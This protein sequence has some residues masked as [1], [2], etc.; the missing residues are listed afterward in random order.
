MT[1][2]TDIF[3]AFNQ[4]HILVIGDIMLDTYTFGDVYRISPEA[5][6][7][8]VNT[9]HT[10]SRLGGAANVALNLKSL[11]AKVS[12]CGIV[13]NDVGAKTIKELLCK[14]EIL[15]SGI[16]QFQQR[17]TTIKN[18]VIAN[19][20]QLLR[21]DTETT[22]AINESESQQLI[23]Q[24]NLILNAEKIDAVI[25]EDYNKGCLT[26]ENISE[27]ILLFKSKNI[28]TAVDPKHINF[29]AYNGAT[30]FKP[31]L[32]ELAEGI[33]YKGSLNELKLNINSIGIEFCKQNNFEYLFAT[34]S[35][36]GVVI[37]DKENSFADAAHVRSIADV[38]GAGDTVI[39]VAT[40]CMALNLPMPLIAKISNIAGGLVCEKVGVVAIDKQEL[41]AETI[42]YLS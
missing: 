36:S 30:L 34:L 6:V 28:P 33:A 40:L 16:L 26:K 3:N 37:C 32:R 23:G 12:I 27:L 19:K 42:K 35:E 17:K 18:R 22:T 25:F 8:I 15:D 41:L 11:G 5:P 38:S 21:V 24:I 29:G 20:H 4:L 13:G 10:E 9:T 39:S 31:N 14:N 2:I 7:P 1:N